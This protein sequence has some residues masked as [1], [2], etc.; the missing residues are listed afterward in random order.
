MKLCNRSKA[1]TAG[2]NFFWGAKQSK[3][4]TDQ[5]LVIEWL[6]ILQSNNQVAL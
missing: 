5:L 4:E 6:F 3:N 2:S 1:H